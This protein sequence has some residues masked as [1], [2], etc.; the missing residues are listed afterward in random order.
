LPQSPP[1]PIGPLFNDAWCQLLPEE[2]S[3][4]TYNSQY[5]QRHS[6]SVPSILAAAKVLHKLQSPM[7]EIEA[8]IFTALGAEVKLE[9]KVF[10]FF[11]DETSKF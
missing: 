8:T 1:P 11:N 4:E 5:L 6:T 2:L 3:L 9:I 7:G 10:G